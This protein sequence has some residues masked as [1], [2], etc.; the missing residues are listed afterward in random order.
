VLYANL[1][2]LE[3][4]VTQTQYVVRIDA[5]V[6]PGTLIPLYYKIRKWPHEVIDTFRI[7]VGSAIDTI[8]A[9]EDC[10]TDFPPMSIENATPITGTQ[11]KLYP[12]PATSILT[13]SAEELIFRKWELFDSYGRLLRHSGRLQHNS[14]E[15]KVSDLSS[16]L[17]FV[18]I[19]DENNHITVKKFVKK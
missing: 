16:G 3:D 11:I 13:I 15:I 4:S 6:P 7:R 1:A 9:P 8:M 18:R 12:N 10:I 5:S 19:T 17:Y 14:V 2:I